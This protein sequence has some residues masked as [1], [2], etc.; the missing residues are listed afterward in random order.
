MK[1][2][3]I[4]FVLIGLVVLALA[5]PGVMAGE[6]PVPEANESVAPAHRTLR[7]TAYFANYHQDASL[8]ADLAM[9]VD[10]C[11][12]GYMTHVIVGLFHCD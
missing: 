10:S 5:G 1:S 11:Q 9:L 2:S 12:R 6:G 4:R 7:C 3:A 8:L